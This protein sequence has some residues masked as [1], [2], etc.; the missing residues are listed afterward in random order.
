MLIALGVPI[1]SAINLVTLRK[2]QT[3]VDLAPAVLLGGLI[4]CAATL[5]GAWPLSATPNDLVL[6]ALLGF[7]QLALPCVLMVGVARHLA[8]QEIALIALLEIVL[9]SLFAWAG[10]GEALSTATLQGGAI[11]LA[12]LIANELL[13]DRPRTSVVNA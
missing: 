7:F 5:P 6:L 3:Q 10:A 9:G 2:M 13:P 12:A 11:V 1:A 8:P 4:S